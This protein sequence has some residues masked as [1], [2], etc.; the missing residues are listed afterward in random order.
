MKLSS[1]VVKIVKFDISVLQQRF[2]ELNLVRPCFNKGLLKNL[3]HG[4]FQKLRAMKQGETSDK[5]KQHIS[6]IHLNDV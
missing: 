4:R 2:I 6:G 1:I 5:K 3:F